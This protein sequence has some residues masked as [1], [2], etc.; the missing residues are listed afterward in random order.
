MAKFPLKLWKIAGFNCFFDL[1]FLNLLASR[2]LGSPIPYK[3]II[4][5]FSNFRSNFSPKKFWTCAGSPITIPALVD[6][7][8]IPATANV[9]ITNISKVCKTVS[10]IIGRGCIPFFSPCLTTMSLI[11]IYQHLRFKVNAHKLNPAEFELDHLPRKEH[12][13]VIQIVK[14]LRSSLSNIFIV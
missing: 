11:E 13:N 4:L 3:C 14:M 9:Y 12:L 5:S 10:S 7:K 2:G 6:P 8:K 1:D